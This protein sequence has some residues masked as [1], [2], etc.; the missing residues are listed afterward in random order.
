MKK[1]LLTALIGLALT[2]GFAQTAVNFTATDCAS[3]SHTLFTELDAGKVVVICWPM[4]CGA[5][6]TGA[7]NC[8][9]AV[10]SFA[11]SNPGQV[12]FYLVDDAGNTS[13]S[14]LSS[15]ASTNSIVADAK[16]G[17]AGNTIKMTDY[18]TSGMPKLVV[19]GGPSH[20]VYYNVNGAGSVSA[21]QSAINNALSAMTGI[22][23]ANKNISAVSVFPNPAT[24][25]AKI[26]YTLTTSVDVTIEVVN[27][28]G[29]KVSFVSLGK[30]SVGKQEYEINLEALSAGSYFIKLN[31]GETSETVKVTVT[32]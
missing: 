5:C 26:N 2:F 20:T 7:K 6:I 14:T 19:L 8:A 9:N 13:C 23:E 29:E 18:G 30:Q 17:N 21:I 15:W 4:P 10:Q 11:T 25:N 32:R 22:A 16:F 3:T 1:V 27:L 24:T 31:T 28:L 12:K